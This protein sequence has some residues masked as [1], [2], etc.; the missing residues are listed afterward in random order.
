MGQAIESDRARL[1]AEGFAEQ[2]KKEGLTEAGL[3]ARYSDEAR[4]EL[5]RRNLLQ[6]E[7]FGKVTVTDSQVQKSFTDNKEKIGR[8]PRALRVL[9]LFVR[10][11]PDSM[12]E[13]AQRK[14][15]EDV[16]MEI[17]GGLAFDEAAKKYSD[18]EKSRAQ[19]GLLPPLL[20]RGPRRP[21]LREG[22][23]HACRWEM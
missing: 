16:E 20:A 6:K 5:L 9:D 19:G 1:G 8:K 12:I 7:V 10:T 17:V 22:R 23:L 14:R 2:L 4:Q 3:R 13:Q 11:T 21:F 15:A 18:D